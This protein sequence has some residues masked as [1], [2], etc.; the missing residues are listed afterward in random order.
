MA[1]GT[2][3]NCSIT[4]SFIVGACELRWWD[5]L[6]AQNPLVY[7]KIHMGAVL[8]PLMW[9][10]LGNTKVRFCAFT[11][12]PTSHTKCLANRMF[13][14]LITAILWLLPPAVPPIHT[15]SHS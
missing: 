9:E 15:H 3:S 1:D 7:Q 11:Q 4:I 2:F 14:K 12:F 5:L 6:P 13:L 10:C 8:C